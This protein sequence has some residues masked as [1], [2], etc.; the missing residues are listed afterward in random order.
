MKTILITCL[1][2]ASFSFGVA[3][4][5]SFNHLAHKFPAIDKP[6]KS[7]Y[8]TFIFR[9]TSEKNI[10][11]TDIKTQS[12]IIIESYTKGEIPHNGEGTIKISVLTIDIKGP[13][14]REIIVKTTDPLQ[15]EYK[16]IVRGEVI[17]EIDEKTKEYNQAMGNLYAKPYQQMFM[18]IKLTD[19]KTDTIYVYNAWKK[20]ME[21]HFGKAPKH[22]SLQAVPEILEPKA[23]GKII[24]TYDAKERNDFDY[25]VD[26]VHINTN[27]DQLPKKRLIIMAL[28]KEDFSD[29]SL[30]EKR[31][32][33]VAKFA[34]MK[35][36][37]GTVKSG[38]VVKY[39]LTLTNIGSDTLYIRKTKSSC[40]CTASKPDKTKLPPMESATIKI[41]FNTYG[42]RGVQSKS[43]TIITNDPEN[44]IQRFMVSG[45]VE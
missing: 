21:L 2:F 35:Y 19:I 5:L 36:D 1:I 33:P 30:R 43:V 17:I 31:K 23:E 40:G 11:I 28:I 14:S 32:A 18:D 39:D 42:R 12:D 13:F 26:Y 20:P 34:S 3:Q 27:D 6:G 9:N 8:H 44:P 4:S 38:D 45:K 10:Q 24:V 22:L 41:S 7:L 29:L 16:L 37:Y 25:I 15:K